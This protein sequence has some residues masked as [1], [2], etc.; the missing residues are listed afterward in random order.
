[1]G[2][3]SSPTISQ[4]RAERQQHPCS[5]AA[6]RPPS[7]ARLALPKS[8]SAISVRGPSKV[9]PL[10]AQKL[11][12]YGDPLYT[13]SKQLKD[14][15]HQLNLPRV[16][17]K[18]LCGDSFRQ[19]RA[20]HL[21]T[22]DLARTRAYLHDSDSDDDEGGRVATPLRRSARAGHGRVESRESPYCGPPPVS[23]FSALSEGRRQRKMVANRREQLAEEAAEVEVLFAQAKKHEE[24]GRKI[25]SVLTKI[26]NT[27]ADLESA[28]GPAYSDTQIIQT[29]NASM[30]RS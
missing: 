22:A 9:S 13:G 11:A 19:F 27:G 29:M 24:I 14:G 6:P 17:V 5:A 10:V 1:M 12:V 8:G 26:E 7:I 20:Q 28:V 23:H 3:E 4:R 25:R 30:F 18:E 21:L 2:D 16:E 15:K